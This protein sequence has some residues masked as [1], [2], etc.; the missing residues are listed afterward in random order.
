MLTLQQ[1][2]ANGLI[3]SPRAHRGFRRAS[4]ILE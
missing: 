4:L 1:T 3:R 2:T